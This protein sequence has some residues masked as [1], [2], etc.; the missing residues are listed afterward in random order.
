MIKGWGWFEVDKR[1]QPTIFKTMNGL[2]EL[3]NAILACNDTQLDLG[4][5]ILKYREIGIARK[6]KCF[7]EIFKVNEQNLLDSLPKAAD[8]RI[9]DKA[10]RKVIHGF[11]FERTLPENERNL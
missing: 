11:L 2:E 6:A 5:A 1:P 8:D 10:S 9:L 3:K 4:F 7:A